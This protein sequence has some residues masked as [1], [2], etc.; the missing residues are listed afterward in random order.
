MTNRI[1]TPTDAP[2][3]PPPKGRLPGPCLC[4]GALRYAVDARR[5]TCR[6]CPLDIT[7]TA[8]EHQEV[9][10]YQAMPRLQDVPFR[11]YLPALL[12]AHH[13]YAATVEPEPQVISTKPTPATHKARI[14]PLPGETPEERAERLAA[15]AD[16]NGVEV[17]PIRWTAAGVPVGFLVTSGERDAQNQPVRRYDVEVSSH[18]AYCPCKASGGCAHLSKVGAWLLDWEAAEREREA[19]KIPKAPVAYANTGPYADLWE[20]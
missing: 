13:C 1:V 14:L 15:Q 17:T 20:A 7:L 10:W 4:G 6:Q 16:L 12:A 18:R 11:L 5:L 3:K 9:L 19:A 2:V 8:Q